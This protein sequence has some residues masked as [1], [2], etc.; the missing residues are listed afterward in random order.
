MKLLLISIHLSKENI[1][2]LSQRLKYV[3]LVFTTCVHAHAHVH[4]APPPH[5]DHNNTP[6]IMG[7]VVCSHIKRFWPV[8]FPTSGVY[9]IL[10][11]MVKACRAD[12]VYLILTLTTIATSGEERQLVGYLQERENLY[13]KVFNM[14]ILLFS[15][16]FM[17][18][19][20]VESHCKLE[21]QV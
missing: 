16:L 6:G 12:M 17:C 8:S 11:C 14:K 10:L 20:V 19:L 13:H 18:L 21:V 2:V 4:T 1:P 7:G 15:K 3:R 9:I 5:S